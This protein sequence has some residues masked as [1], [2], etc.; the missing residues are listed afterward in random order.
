MTYIRLRSWH[1]LRGTRTRCGRPTSTVDR[2][3]DTLPLDERSRVTCL[4]QE[5]HDRERPSDDPVPG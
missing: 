4:Q 5:A 3:T 2:T 1:I